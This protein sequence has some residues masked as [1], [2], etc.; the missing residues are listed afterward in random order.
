MAEEQSSGKSFFH[1]LPGIITAIAGLITAVGGFLL[2]LNKTGCIGSKAEKTEQHVNIDD[3][4][5]SK[6]NEADEKPLKKSSPT[7]NGN[8]SYAPDS[9]KHTTRQLVYKIS[10]VN[11]EILPNDEVVLNVKLKCINNSDYE[12]HFYAN[13]LGAKVGDDN[14]GPD[15]YSPSGNYQSIPPRSF[16]NIEYNFRLPRF[17][18]NFNFD[19]YDVD[20]LIGTSAFV[21]E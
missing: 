15:I 9:I 5:K 2:I 3:T 19:I 11:A 16:K 14:Y 17:T 12:Y 1:T 7:S 4:G 13:Y 8:V 21:V 20:K 10:E 18:K 6:D